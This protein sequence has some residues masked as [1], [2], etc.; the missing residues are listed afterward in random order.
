MSLSIIVA[1]VSFLV[2]AVVNVLDKFVLNKKVS[3]QTFVFFS[4]IF[5][6]PMVLL[7]PF[8]VKLPGSAGDWF[9]TVFSGFTFCL[10]LWT[11]YIGLKKAEATHFVPFI[12]GTI[13]LFLIIFSSL[14]LGE[15]FTPVQFLAILFLVLGSFAVSFEY[16][17]HGSSDKNNLWWGVATGL[18]SA[19]SMA[20]AKHLYDVYGF[21]SGFVLARGAMIGIFGVLLLFSA[22]VRHEVFGTKKEKI[23]PEKLTMVAVNKILGVLGIVLF[24]YAVSMGSV[25]IINALAGVQ[26][27]LLIII[28]FFLSKFHPRFFR[29]YYSKRELAQEFFAVCLIGAGLA[30]LVR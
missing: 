21:Y 23:K 20:A 9:W 22:V 24:Q 25:T 12:G 30:L 29:E 13:P 4:S 10:S 8:G 18:L 19:G 7:I 6:L 16:T 14:F 5:L 17:I 27:A 1:L 2:L 15:K 11:M 28:V 26:Y 3:P